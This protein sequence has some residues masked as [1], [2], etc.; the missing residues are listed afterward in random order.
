MIHETPDPK[1]A[2]QSSHRGV[3]LNLPDQVV[4]A[5]FTR[6]DAQNTALNDTIGDTI[7]R[8]ILA[9]VARS[10]QPEWQGFRSIQCSPILVLASHPPRQTDISSIK[11]GA[12]S[13]HITFCNGKVQRLPYHNSANQ[14]IS[15]IVS[16]Q[17]CKVSS[18]IS[19]SRHLASL[20][21]GDQS[22]ADAKST[23]TI[24]EAATRTRVDAE[25]IFKDPIPSDSYFLLEADHGIVIEKGSEICSI[26]A[27]SADFKARVDSTLKG[28]PFR[29]PDNEGA[30]TLLPSLVGPAIDYS[31]GIY[32]RQLQSMVI[33]QYTDALIL[34][35]APSQGM[36]PSELLSRMFKL[37]PILQSSRPTQ[38][39]SEIT[40][41]E[42]PGVIIA[43]T[44]GA[45]TVNRLAS[46]FAKTPEITH[47]IK[48]S[49]S[50][51]RLKGKVPPPVNEILEKR[52]RSLLSPYPVN[53]ATLPDL[54]PKMLTF[55]VPLLE[56]LKIEP[57]RYG[58]LAIASF[59]FNVFES[60]FIIPGDQGYDDL[61]RAFLSAPN[62]PI[63]SVNDIDTNT[64]NSHLRVFFIHS[65]LEYE[66]AI[67]EQRG[68]RLSAET[69]AAIEKIYKVPQN[70]RISL[71]KSIGTTQSSLSTPLIEL[72]LPPKDDLG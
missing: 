47:L 45:H 61:F 44:L 57:E 48:K 28:H 59:A 60:L 7:K 32:L 24:I 41:D 40:P 6:F 18:Q 71:G 36:T 19:R 54:N 20:L 9:A 50:D 5:L 26:R 62:K 56:G 30:A 1:Q 14:L 23:N 35:S 31:L 38:L 2:D 66:Q 8:L 51:R 22:R 29:A 27:Y 65:T 11:V 34:T 21:L 70:E 16:H 39:L 37:R 42:L 17:E 12:R 64:I 69:V 52:L 58:Q 46:G 72:S 33:E 3:G 55:D 13:I 49:A 53:K 15:E 63:R 25:F 68:P 67:R 4:R 10:Q 43:L